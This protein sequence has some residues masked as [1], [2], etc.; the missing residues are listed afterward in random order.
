VRRRISG[1]AER[2]NRQS[3][4]PHPALGMVGC[5][6]RGATAMTRVAK[7]ICKTARQ[8][9]STSVQIFLAILMLFDYQSERSEWS[10]QKR[11]L[12]HPDQ[13]NTSEKVE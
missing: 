2:Q 8:N 12:Y 11:S 9:A 1:R 10:L 3:T 13:A 7:G 6:A 5:C 4:R